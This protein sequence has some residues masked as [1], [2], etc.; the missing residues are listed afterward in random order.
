MTDTE[1]F[2]LFCADHVMEQPPRAPNP[3]CWR[4]VAR[5]LFEAYR[6]RCRQEQRKPWSQGK[7]VERI[8]STFPNAK[9]SDWRIVDGEWEKEWDGLRL[10]GIT[11]NIPPRPRTFQER[12]WKPKK[13]LYSQGD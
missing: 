5:R 2:L 3:L 6:I 9:L 11:A 4:V 10:M 1:F 7:F 8:N 12:A 13:T